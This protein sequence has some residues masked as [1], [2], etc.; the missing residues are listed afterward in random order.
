MVDDVDD[1]VALIN[2]LDGDLSHASLFICH[3]ES[4]VGRDNVFH[5]QYFLEREIVPWPPYYCRN[6]TESG[7]HVPEH[8]RAK[9][10]ERPRK[11]EERSFDE[12][13]KGTTEVPEESKG[14]TE[15][16]RGTQLRRSSVQILWF[17]A[18]NY[19]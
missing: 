8:S 17:G 7:S 16:E 5:N 4:F 18:K 13:L 19:I 10:R 2:I 1:P 12:G 9:R 11:N 14:T 3:V 15:E 6:R